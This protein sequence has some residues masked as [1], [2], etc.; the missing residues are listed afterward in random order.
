MLN[1][2]ANKLPGKLSV[3]DGTIDFYLRV[4]TVIDKSKTVLDLGAG[5]GNWLNDKQAKVMTKTIQFLK[6]DVKRLY[7]ADIDRAVLKNKSSHKNFLIRKNKIP[8]KS[9]SIDVIISDWTFEHIKKPEIFAIEINRIL[10][11]NGKICVRTPHR[12]NYVSL[13]NTLTEGTSIKNFLL[14]KSQPGKKNYFK[15]YYK[16][17]TYKDIKNLFSNYKIEYFIFNPNPA[18][19]FDSIII[20]HI[21]KIIHTVL[22]N[23]FVG[24]I[25][26]ILTKK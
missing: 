3:N 7:A 16:I 25:Y 14:K 15:S 9:N 18:Y 1:K 5:S 17:N 2:I 8:L 21:F 10:K 4:R 11:K 19:Y 23:F 13:V 20:Y 12:F 22:P 24:I 6:N 26:C